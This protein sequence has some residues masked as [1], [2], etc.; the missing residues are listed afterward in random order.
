MNEKNKNEKTFGDIFSNINN[1]TQETKNTINFNNILSS[2]P[3]NENSIES[4]S[5]TLET[6]FN[7]SLNEKPTPIFEEQKPETEENKQTTNIFGIPKE[8]SPKFENNSL[9]LTG[10]NSYPKINFEN[11]KTLEESSNQISNDN[12]NKEKE[13]SISP[14]FEETNTQN[15]PNNPFFDSKINLIET[16]KHNTNNQNNK[17]DTTTVKNFDVKIIKKKEPLMKFIIGVISYAIFILLLLIGITLIVYISD[18]KIRAAKGD[19]ST[20]K[21]NAYVVLTGSMLPDIQVYDVVITKKVEAENLNEGDVITFASSDTRFLNTIIT[22]RIIKKNYD[23]KTKEYTFQTKGDNNNVAD[24]ALVQSD[25]IYG[26]VILKIPKLGYLQQF[27]A[28][29][30]GYILVVIVPCL[31]VISYDVVKLSKG[32]K[33]KKKIKVQK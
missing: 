14:F 4:E 26:K 33:K 12:L 3:K 24:S 28:E 10:I 13:K 22:H 17:I 11:S 15:Q 18:I 32:L 8:S 29:D 19:Y 9:S 2:S 23:A 6:L 20:P 27:L 7:K 5:V 16:P 21:Y 25:K 30:G 1:D 31:I